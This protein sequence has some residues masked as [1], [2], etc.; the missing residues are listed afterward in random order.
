[1]ATSARYAES[2]EQMPIISY[3]LDISRISIINLIT[4]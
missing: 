2:R 1:M 3:A 4:E